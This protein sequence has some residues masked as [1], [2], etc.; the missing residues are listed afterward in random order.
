MFKEKDGLLPRRSRLSA[1]ITTLLVG[2]VAGVGSVQA[3]EP[4]SAPGSDVQEIAVTGSRI[5][6]DGMS[7]PTPVTA[8]DAGELD[9]M[10]PGNMIEAFDQIPQFLNNESPQTQSNFAG[11]AGASNLNLRGIG[12]K[13]TL[14]LVNGRRIVGSNRLGSVDINLLPES[15]VQRVDVVTGGASAAYGTDAVA[16]VT[17]FILDTNY[18][19]LSIRGQGGVTDRDDANSQ[20][21]AISW[22][23][24]IGQRGHIIGSFEF[25]DRDGIATYPDRDW[26][27]G[28]GTVTNPEWMETGEGPRLLI[29]PQVVS[30]SYTVGGLINQPGSA[31]DRLMFQ[32]DGSAVPFVESS[33]SNITGGSGSQSIAEQYGGGSGDNIQALTGGQGGLIPDNDRHSAFLYGDYELSPNLTLFGQLIKGENS[34]RALGNSPVLFGNWGATIFAENAYL[35]DNVRDI[36]AREGLDSFS[37][38]RMHGLAD[39]GGGEMAATNNTSSYTVGFQANLEGGFFDGWV[40]DGYY[41]YGKNENEVR[42]INFIRTDRL[43]QSLDAVRDPVSGEITCHATLQGNEAYSDCVPVNLFGAG[44]ASQAALDYLR[45]PDKVITENIRQRYAEIAASGDLWEGWGAGV[46]SGAFG[47]SWRE[48]SIAKELGP[49]HLMALSSPVNDPDAGLRGIPGAFAGH[50]EIF[51][52]SG[53]NE[54]RGAY[55]VKEVFGEVLVPLVSNVSGFDQLDMSL[56][57]RWAEYSGSGEVWSWKAGLDWQVYNDLRLRGTLSRDIRAANLS[58]RFD[59]QSQGASGDDPWFNNENYA[60]SQVIGGNPNVEPEEADTLTVG[61]VYQPSYMPSLSLSMDY[62]DIEVEGVIEQLGVQRILDDCYEGAASLC[63]QITRDPDT[64][65]ITRVENVFLNINQLAVSGVDVEASYT[66]EVNFFGSDYEN[67]RLRL[68]G[69]YL[70]ENALTNQ[71][72]APVDSAGDVGSAGLPEYRWTLSAN[73][74]NGPWSLYLQQRY[75]D[76][77]TL[78]SQWIQGVD[79]DD[80]SVD[81]AWY[82][83]LNMAYDVPLELSGG[84]LQLFLNVTNLLDEDPPVSAG[85]A[86]FFG[87]TQVN[88]R[89]H[90]VLGRRYT[91]GFRLDF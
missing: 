36:M 25:Y 12:A 3:Q 76:G 9:N 49:D 50:S 8:I 65:R 21:Y 82:T 18:E 81:E 57:A 7:T 39:L 6:R 91:A 55:D 31:L 19:G 87:A 80:N 17:N 34:T 48:D 46:V 51:Q 42:L 38:D 32:P 16:G 83:D 10:S 44:N 72:A 78:N 14:V 23:T 28:W 2:S 62:Y 22:G 47:A 60:F 52:F 27:Q 35:P 79:I 71:G 58:E 24:R 29:A 88:Q 41:Q 13:R 5:Q 43:F 86:S 37:F 45:G 53:T 67:L 68:L 11:S 61:F 73:Y 84:N 74:T 33:L 90:D 75:V 64:N 40:V 70:R 89:V 69:S 4:A 56:A 63:E 66:R 59:A 54:L 85:Y 1:M 26:Y 30:T 20:E 15:M 77:G